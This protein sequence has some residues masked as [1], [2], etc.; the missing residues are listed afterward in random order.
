MLI[1]E[2]HFIICLD[3]SVIMSFEFF[4]AEIIFFFKKYLFDEF[5][6]TK[7]FKKAS[8]G[9]KTLST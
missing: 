8:N 2:K 9:I 4:E 5:N 3:Q 1:E 6:F 7:T